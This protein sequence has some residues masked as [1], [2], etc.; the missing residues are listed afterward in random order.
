MNEV[1]IKKRIKLS[2]DLFI[3]EDSYLLYNNINEKTITQ[4]LSIYLNQQF[5]DYDV[6]CEYNGNVDDDSE[7]KKIDLLYDDLKAANLLKPL[8]TELYDEFI[9]R[10]VYPDIIIHKRGK[11]EP[12]NLCIFEV[13]KDNSKIKFEYDKLKLKAYTTDYHGNIF[14]YKLGVFIEFSIK[15]APQYNI[16]YYKDGEK[17]EDNNLKN[18]L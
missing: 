16:S 10:A 7:R 14:F 5:K 13:K 3:E 11:N 18:H 2:L 9:E 12:Y 17:Q 1:E 15:D 4:R 8:E 6:D